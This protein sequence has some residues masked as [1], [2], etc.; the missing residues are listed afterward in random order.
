[1]KASKIGST[2]LARLSASLLLFLFLV[3]TFMA[4]VPNTTPASYAVG[5][6]TV[7]ANILFC[8]PIT[9]TNSQSAAT[10]ANFDQLLNVTWASYSSHL[11]GNLQNVVFYDSS[12]VKLN[13]WCESNCNATSALGQVWVNMSTDTI[14]G[15]GG[16]QTIYLGMY[17]TST[18][19]FN[20]VGNWGDYP[21]SFS[22]FSGYAQ[23]DNGKKVFPFYDN[24]AGVS[25]A[26]GWLTTSGGTGFNA[27][28]NN[29]ITISSTGGGDW[30]G[31][32]NTY[33][34]PQTYAVDSF[35]NSKSANTFG[36]GSSSGTV[37]FTGGGQTFVFFDANA[38]HWGIDCSCA[39]ASHSGSVSAS[40]G[41]IITGY[42]PTAV[43]MQMYANYSSFATDANVV[44]SQP[45]IA[46]SFSGNNV[47][48]Q[49][50]RTRIMPPSKIMP[51]PVFGALTATG[52]VP[53][54]VTTSGIPTGT[55]VTST[56]QTTTIWQGI[57]SSLVP[58]S[59]GTFGY[60]SLPCIQTNSSGTICSVTP[61]VGNV[62]P[63]Y[64]PMKA[65]SMSITFKAPSNVNIGATDLYMLVWSGNHL[66][67]LLQYTPN[68]AY[69]HLAN[70]CVT[71]GVTATKG[72]FVITNNTVYTLNMLVK[73]GRAHV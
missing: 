71:G 52:N 5:C 63:I 57:N 10:L 72:C 55:I 35:I 64:E 1:M 44:T 12:G 32:Y 18:N 9:I 38:A 34:L 54:A 27:I 49:W 39:G 56:T 58:S 3:L 36:V 60:K 61:L 13:A 28:V 40:T 29:G 24:F 19:N 2:K 69:M 22:S 73:I 37:G 7:P 47:L 23:N 46:T 21:T 25:L 14:S 20:A 17:Q 4:I 51:V 45:L 30:Y 8:V 41:Y 6:G 67:G 65:I 70:T 26:A 42:T 66:T 68:V 31:I 62:Y 50:I 33:H 59:S 15:S 11:A 48:F 43:S 53:T 16:T